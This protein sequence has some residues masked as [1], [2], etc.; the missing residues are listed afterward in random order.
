MGNAIFEI[1]QVPDETA[2]AAKV[3]YPEKILWARLILADI[4]ACIFLIMK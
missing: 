2:Y 3:M 4:F 1:L